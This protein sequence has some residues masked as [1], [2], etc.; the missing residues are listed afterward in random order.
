[1]RVWKQVVFWQK[2]SKSTLTVRNCDYMRESLREHLKWK[3]NSI[4]E[5]QNTNVSSMTRK[6]INLELL[7][8]GMRSCKEKQIFVLLNSFPKVLVLI[9]AI[10]GCIKR[11]VLPLQTT[12]NCFF[13]GLKLCCFKLPRK[14]LRGSAI[15]TWLLFLSFDFFQM[16]LVK[17]KNFTHSTSIITA[18]LYLIN[19]IFLEQKIFQF[20]SSGFQNIF[21]L[22][23]FC[24]IKQFV[25]SSHAGT[26]KMTFLNI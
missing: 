23:A 16:S 6:E 9:H 4:T 11:V 17:S 10:L 2:L 5:N 7:K 26:K 25:N 3:E 20:L 24:I 22:L 19:F 15:F 18:R 13:S 12:E 1:M 21:R 14:M 8:V